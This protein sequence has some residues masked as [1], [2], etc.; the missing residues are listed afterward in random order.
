MAVRIGGGLAEASIVVTDGV[1]LFLFFVLLNCTGLFA[2]T[3][4][5]IG[6]ALALEPPIDILNLGAFFIPAG[7]P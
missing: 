4:G 3:F 1:G 7:V 2:G 6:A 5:S